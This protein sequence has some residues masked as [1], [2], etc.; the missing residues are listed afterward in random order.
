[1]VSVVFQE[2]SNSKSQLTG[3]DAVL[4]TKLQKSQKN[5]FLRGKIVTVLR[6]QAQVQQ[7]LG[8]VWYP[9][10]PL[11]RSRFKCLFGVDQ[12][13][14][15]R[16]EILSGSSLK[17]LSLNLKI[18]RLCKGLQFSWQDE[19]R[20]YDWQPEYFYTAHNLLPSILTLIHHFG[21]WSALH[22]SF[23]PP[24]QILSIRPLFPE[25]GRKSAFKC[26]H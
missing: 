18:F 11:S 8:Q 16:A 24:F 22:F 15:S 19:E 26:C 23:D 12:G 4:A 9:I 7:A 13:I 6:A 2:C 17:I 25:T 20:S 3:H 5:L 21:S 10:L 1:M 14:P